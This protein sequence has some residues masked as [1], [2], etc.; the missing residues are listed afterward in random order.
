MS[1]RIVTMIRNTCVTDNLSSYFSGKASLEDALQDTTET[2]L[3]SYISGTFVCSLCGNIVY[4]KVTTDEHGIFVSDT[5]NEIR[6]GIA[7]RLLKRN[8]CEKCAENMIKAPEI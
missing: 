6:G 8:I 1:K 3:A 5:R 4:P 7:N 2:F